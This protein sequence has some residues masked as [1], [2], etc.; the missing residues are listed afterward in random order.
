M[1]QTSF[2]CY[3][4]KEL[5]SWD[6]EKKI[7]SKEKLISDRASNNESSKVENKRLFK[8]TYKFIGAPLDNTSCLTFRRVQEYE[9]GITRTV[10][11]YEKSKDNS[12]IIELALEEARMFEGLTHP[13]ILR[14][15]DVFDEENYLFVVFENVKGQSLLD[16][17]NKKISL[18]KKISEEEI[19][20]I[21]HQ[22][23]NVI[24]HLHKNNLCHRDIKPENFFFADPDD[25]ISLRL[26]SCLTAINSSD[27]FLQ[28]F[29]GSVNY[30]SYHIS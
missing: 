19:A 23:L 24:Y 12:K 6:K 17:I 5:P 7:L 8:E 26:V 18:N 25:I 9:T 28:T 1:G 4:P 2:P 16:M 30:H 20:C 11:I 22:L 27:Q 21:M 10:K 14:L 15:Y 29:T 13:N 3:K